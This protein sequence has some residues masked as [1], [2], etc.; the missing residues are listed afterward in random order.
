[1]ADKEI[2]FEEA[3]I[4]LDNIID[5]LE[6]GDLNIDNAIDEFKRGI[7]L[8]NQCYKK[9]EETEGKIKLILE[10]NNGKIKE[11]NFEMTE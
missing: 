8:Y 5:R 4:E 2:K 10:D 1:M 7:K 11:S 6:I 3:I 9:I